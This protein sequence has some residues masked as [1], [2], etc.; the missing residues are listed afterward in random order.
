[1]T[2]F[3]KF[4]RSVSTAAVLIVGL[5]A[6]EVTAS[7]VSS[8]KGMLQSASKASDKA[9]FETILKMALTTWPSKQEKILAVAEDVNSEWMRDE[10]IEQLTAIRE[11]AAAAEKASRDR[12]IVYYLDPVLWN[13]QVE[14]GAGSSTGDT[15]EKSLALGVSFDRKF[16]ENWEHDLDLNFDFASSDGVTTRQKF[17][18]TY[19]VLWR[20]WEHLYAISYT[21]LELDR[22]S[23]YDYRVLENIGIGYK[24]F[25]NKRHGLRF[26]AGPG[27]R[28]SRLELTEETETEYL[29]RI[30][31]TYRLQLSER[32]A[33]RDRASSTF[34]GTSTT[35]TNKA[36]FSAQLNSHLTARLSF[37]TGYDSAS[38]EGTSA[39]DTATRATLVYGF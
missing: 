17:Q 39:W 31:A 22:F 4:F 11:A 34:G 29:G 27:I 36:E 20:V 12:G 16:G 23:G 26:E 35:F 5:G 33:F 9:A 7:D 13:A 28:F 3:S 38:P 21:D 10:H 32:I 15:S 6:A 14:L 24:L 37:E 18:T 19:E 8:V 2:R 25:E 1:M 30:S